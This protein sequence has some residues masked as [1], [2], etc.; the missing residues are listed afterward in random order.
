MY[1]YILSGYTIFKAYAHYRIKE[2][3][4]LFFVLN[5]G[6]LQYKFKTQT[7]LTRNCEAQYF[8]LQSG[9]LTLKP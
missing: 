1:L 7:L 6:V 9:Y 2:D 8:K 5:Q 3:K 4:T